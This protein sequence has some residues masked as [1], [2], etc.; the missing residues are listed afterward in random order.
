M[1]VYSISI[2]ALSGYK[3]EGVLSRSVDN[4]NWTFDKIS[5]KEAFASIRKNIK[6]INNLMKRNGRKL[7][8]VYY[9][10]NVSSYETETR[11]TRHLYFNTNGYNLR[12]S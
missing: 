3:K 8:Q 7:N 2:F 1:K 9:A 4:M 6:K 12:K 11:K 5:R 10:I